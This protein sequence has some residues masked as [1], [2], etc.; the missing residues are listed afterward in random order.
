MTTVRIPT[1]GKLTV[2]EELPTKV[3][4]HTMI[5]P[6]DWEIK[7]LLGPTMTVQSASG[8]MLTLD[9]KVNEVEFYG[10]YIK[11]AEAE[12]AAVQQSKVSRRRQRHRKRRRQV[13]EGNR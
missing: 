6:K 9:N 7:E 3:N 12:R 2:S 11:E 5:D 4:Y 10:K 8:G 1:I 13:D